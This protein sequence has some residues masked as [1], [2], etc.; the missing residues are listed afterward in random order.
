MPVL[1]VLCA[2]G[3]LRLLEVGEGLDADGSKPPVGLEIRR[4]S[5][6]L[7]FGGDGESSIMSTHPVESLCFPLSL[8]LSLERRVSGPL[9]TVDVLM[10]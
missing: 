1:T 10:L 4:R 6:A 9:W 2:N 3:L 5:L 8:P 7:S